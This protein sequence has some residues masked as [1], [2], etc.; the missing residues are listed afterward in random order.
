MNA[1]KTAF[2]TVSL[3]SSISSLTLGQLGPTNFKAH[4]YKIFKRCYVSLYHV[5]FPEECRNLSASLNIE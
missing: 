1:H 5:S 2:P 3:S 4:R